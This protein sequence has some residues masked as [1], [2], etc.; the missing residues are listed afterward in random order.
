MINNHS[1]DPCLF[2]FEW[3]DSYWC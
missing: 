2:L 1:I 3:V